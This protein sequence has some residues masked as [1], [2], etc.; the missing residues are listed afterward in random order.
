MAVSNKVEGVDELSQLMARIQAG[1]WIGEIP[2]EE[3][4]EL[5]KYL[6][7]TLARA[8]DGSEFEIE[9]DVLGS[10]I[11]LFAIG[12][13][14]ISKDISLGVHINGADSVIFSISYDATG[15]KINL[16]V[17]GVYRYNGPEPSLVGTDWNDVLGNAFEVIGDWMLNVVATHYITCPK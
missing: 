13:E 7:N 14:S 5:K 10:T 8:S 4:E 15:T 12:G 11:S 16:D 2:V 1:G 6:T 3:Y 17:V 9:L